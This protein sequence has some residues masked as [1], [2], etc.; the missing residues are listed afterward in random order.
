M[1][2]DRASLPDPFP[3]AL[4]LWDVDHTLIEN[5]G[6]SKDAYA[7]AFKLIAGR[8]PEVQPVTH[9]RTDFLIMRAL[10]EANGIDTGGFE[11]IES[12]RPFLVSAMKEVGPGLPSR[13]YVLP[14][15]VEALRVLDGVEAVTQ[16]ALTGN[17][18]ENA[19]AKLDPFDLTRWLD[20]E[21]GGFGSD[22]EIRSDLVRVAQDKASAKYGREYDA[23]STILIGDTPLD[24]KA[25]QDGGAKV[26]AVATGVHDLDELRAAG[27]DA[28]LQDLSNL[29]LFLS[30]LVE[31]RQ[32]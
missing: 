8:A 17:V 18:V 26:I 2:A 6:V 4:V 25:A 11:T 10:L 12:F 19:R 16:S 22:A 28:A 27:P 23:E 15:V 1:T 21:V 7:L 29:D 32:R 20:M 30:T 13:G 31:V 3:T 24:V 5:G 14:G 9:G